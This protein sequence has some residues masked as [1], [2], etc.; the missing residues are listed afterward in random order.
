M[1][2]DVEL[3]VGDI[4][5]PT[6]VGKALHGVDAVVHLCATVGV[7]Q[8]MY[9]IDDYTAVNNLGQPSC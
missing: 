6:V 3:I 7:G 9:Q 2:N 1:N 5:D 4:R 8:S